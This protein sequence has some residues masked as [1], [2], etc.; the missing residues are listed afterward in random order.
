MRFIPDETYVA[1]LA[2]YRSMV[3]RLEA[4]N[5]LTK[6]LLARSKRALSKSRV[7]L[8]TPAPKVWP[9]RQGF[10]LSE[11]KNPTD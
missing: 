5:L 2:R 11:D 4:G 9:G 7:L 3:R 8:A 1:A 6:E 10:N